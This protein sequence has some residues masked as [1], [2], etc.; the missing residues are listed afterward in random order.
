MLLPDFV[1]PRGRTEEPLDRSAET[2]ECYQAPSRFEARHVTDLGNKTNGNG[3]RHT[4]ESCKA[5]T[6]GDIDQVGTI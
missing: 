5:S 2:Q 4:S 3:Q 6:S 1:M